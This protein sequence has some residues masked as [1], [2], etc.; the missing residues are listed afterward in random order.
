MIE[1]TEVLRFLAA[2]VGA[3]ATY[4]ERVGTGTGRGMMVT[5]VREIERRLCS[6]DTYSLEGL[7]DLFALALAHGVIAGT[8]RN[9]GTV[10]GSAVAGDRPP[11]ALAGGDVSSSPHD[12][13]DDG[14]N[15]VG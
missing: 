10:V 9:R 5:Y 13:S 1:K 6:E 7:Y 11:L 2:D 4:A 15:R 12:D 3:R 14:D 8:V